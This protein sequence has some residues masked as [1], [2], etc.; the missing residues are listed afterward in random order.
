MKE[1]DRVRI[2]AQGEFH[3]WEGIVQPF[4][5]RNHQTH[6]GAWILVP[7]HPWQKREPNV[8]WHF[9]DNELVLLPPGD[10]RE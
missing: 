1:G 2:T 4:P 5:V 6:H 8:A 7:G 10:G 3:G 9:N